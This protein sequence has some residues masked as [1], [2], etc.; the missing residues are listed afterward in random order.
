MNKLFIENS[1]NTLVEKL[2]RGALRPEDLSNATRENI[3]ELD[4]KYHAFVVSADKGEMLRMQQTS[5]GKGLF[6]HVPVG[7]KDIYNTADFPT[8]MGSALWK[9]FKPGNDARSLFNLKREGAVVA[10]K[11]VT[12]EFAVHALNETLNP[13]DVT[14]TPGTSSSGS[15]VAVALG[16]VP[17]ATGTQT[18]G[19]II[20][21]AS[22]C[23]IYGMKPSFGFIPRT[24]VLKTTDSLDTLGFFSVHLEDL[25]R[26]FD[27]MRVHGLDYPISNVAITDTTRQQK[28]EGR[29]WRVGFVRTHTW[30][31]AEPYA[32]EAFLAFAKKLGEERGFEVV[33]A[34]L[35]ELLRQAHETHETIYD[36]A[37]SYYFQNEYKHAEDISPVMQEM[38]EK[39][40]AIT[41]EMY[42]VALA[43]Q[44][45]ML[46]AM[47]E[48]LKE[49]EVL[50]TLSTAGEA[51]LREVREKPDSSLIWTLTHLPVVG[52]PA[53]RSPDNLPF[54]FQVVARKYNDYLLLSF[55][56]T[57]R[58]RNLI[59]ARAGY[60]L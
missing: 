39:G 20:R 18:A 38:I 60:F 52:V 4:S 34:T 21:P 11:T 31:D 36:K 59:P 30:D 41:P 7:V 35:P 16:M 12:A 40:K 57:L 10:G 26:G 50:I 49:F 13:Y 1:I 48:Y 9:N 43:R 19:S 47:D 55:L 33:D 3:S 15:A 32:Q 45:E 25:R 58:E 6:A 37:L 5:A 24:G 29:P 54:G 44:S 23:G 28:R 51:P 8:Q 14:R 42:Q 56:D 53:F 17:F 22:F 2:H 46:Y 27:A